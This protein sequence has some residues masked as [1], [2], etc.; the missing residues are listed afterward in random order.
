MASKSLE[1]ILSEDFSNISRVHD[2][3]N[4]ILDDFRE[5]W[6]YLSK[7]IRIVLYI[8]AKHEAELENW[9]W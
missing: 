9:D 7:E 4:H 6:P 3:R 8:Y 5:I 1:E 2:W